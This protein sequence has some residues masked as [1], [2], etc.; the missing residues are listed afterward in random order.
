MQSTCN[1]RQLNPIFVAQTESVE[2]RTKFHNGLYC[3]DFHETRSF[4]TDFHSVQ[5]V[6]KWELCVYF[7]PRVRRDCHWAD[8]HKIVLA[9]QLIFN[10]CLSEFHASPTNC[11][12]PDTVSWT[13]G[14]TSSPRKTL[15]LLLRKECTITF[16][17]KKK[18]F[19]EDGNVVAQLLI[20]SR[21]EPVVHRLTRR[22]KNACYWLVRLTSVPKKRPD[23]HGVLQAL[24]VLWCVH[25]I[26]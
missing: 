23:V 22:N 24:S 11:S 3:T 1:V 25:R 15:G 16:F 14:H 10:N 17:R 20:F 18:K 4:R 7:R 2:R 12:V 8:F 5:K 19:E 13:D 9:C 21:P 6:C 26:I